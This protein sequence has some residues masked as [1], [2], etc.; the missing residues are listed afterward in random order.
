MSADPILMVDGYKLDHRRQ[1]PAKTERVYS[2][3]TPRM[4]RIQGQTEV[5]FL[6]L[7]Y[8]IQ[9]Y[10]VDRFERDFFQ[11]DFDKVRVNYLRRLNGYLGPN[12]IGTDHLEALHE[13]GY[14]PLKFWALPEGTRVPLR[15]PML[16]VENTHDD[17]AWLV[18]YFETIMSNVLWLPCTS[19]TTASRFRD[20]LDRACKASGGIEEF[21][22]W[23]GHDFSFRGMAG[24]EAAGLSGLGHLVFFEGTDTIPA[25][26]LAEK[27]YGMDL[28]YEYLIGGSVAATEHSVMC[29]GGQMGEL[30]TFEHLLNLYPS[31]IVSVVSD[32]WDLWN[33]LTDILPKLKDRIMAREGRL[34]IRPDSGDPV[35]IICGDPSAPIGSPAHKGVIQLLWETFGGTTTSTGHRLLDTHIGCIYGDSINYERLTAILDNLWKKGFSSSNM[36]FGVGSYCVSPETPVLC[37]DLVWR[38]AGELV[39]GQEIIAFDED[40]SFGEGKHAARRYRTAEIVCNRPAKKPCMR[41]YTD[42]GNPI[43][44]SFDHP[45]LVWTKNRQKGELFFGDTPEDIQVERLPRDGGLVW[46]TGEELQP[47]DQIACLCDPWQVDDT[48]EG[49]WLAGVFDGEGSLSVQN[50][51]DRIPAWKANISQNEGA[52]LGRIRTA[53]RDRGFSFYENPR[54]CRQII[55]TGGWTELLRFLG[56]IRPD[57]LLEKLPKIVADMPALSRNRTYK[58]AT[59]TAIEDVGHVEVASIQTSCG[60]FVTGGYLSHNTYQYTTRDT[61]GFAMKA[62]SVKIDGEERAI[63]KQPITDDGMK[64]SAKGRLSVIKGPDGRLSLINEATPEQEAK[65][66]LTTVWKD[67]EWF[68]K[69]NLEEIRRIARS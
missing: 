22:G 30:E 61:Y 42:I 63:F 66:E 69:Q 47:G 50:E 3:W 27:Y 54:K 23:Q 16:T 31:G 17:F 44:A 43:T 36:V 38:P 26:E 1:Y 49:G 34:V 59:V 35:E 10:L 4:S 25:I 41:V 9:R 39:E 40:P 13:L 21:V 6:G 33:V 60:T 46:R 48:R 68:R 37:A 57:R 32:T 20:I 5:V 55:L 56:T 53:L 51:G 29:A 12:T 67:G 45:W 65:S 14:L 8:F 7:Q 52:V 11:V 64:N 18:N 19:A 2:N 24:L 58:L 15:I 28:P 62:T